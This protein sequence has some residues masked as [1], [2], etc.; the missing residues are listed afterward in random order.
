MDDGEASTREA[1]AEAMGTLMKLVSEKSLYPY[2]EKLDKIKEAKVK[3]YYQKASSSHNAIIAAPKLKKSP[4][5]V[6][7]AQLSVRLIFKYVRRLRC[8]KQRLNR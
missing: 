6:P 2:I 4:K 8:T 1:S 7:K 3:D 5:S